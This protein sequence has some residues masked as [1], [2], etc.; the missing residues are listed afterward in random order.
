MTLVKIFLALSV[1]IT[2]LF[3]TSIEG[4][5]LQWVQQIGGNWSETVNGVCEDA[6]GNVYVTGALGG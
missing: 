1:S 3:P 4:Q 2:L 5:D 6:N